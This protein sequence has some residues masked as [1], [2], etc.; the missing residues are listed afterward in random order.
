M[1]LLLLIINYIAGTIVIILIRERENVYEIFPVP[2][3]GNCTCIY[4]C[5][6]VI[7]KSTCTLHVHYMLWDV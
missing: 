5:T 1:F 7:V 2:Y 4:T 6:V 3:P